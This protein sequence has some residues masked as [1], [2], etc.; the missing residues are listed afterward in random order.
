LTART[1]YAMSKQAVEVGWPCEGLHL[2]KAGQDVAERLSS[3]AV[4]SLLV[5]QEGAAHA[6]M[7]AA[8]EALESFARADYLLGRSDGDGKPTWLAFYDGRELDAFKASG[9]MRLGRYEDA[10]E[11]Y[12]VAVECDEA[13]SRNRASRTT[14]LARSQLAQAD[15]GD[16]AR[17]AEAALV[18][19]EDGVA[20]TRVIDRLKTLHEQF[21][22]YRSIP[23]VSSFRDH[24][25][26]LMGGGRVDGRDLV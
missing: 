1:Y 8:T 11:L 4:L 19:V 15:V 10:E 13:Y 25:Q 22:D 5:A 17:T 18:A 12:R 14:N 23:A 7:G 3:P 20:S 24:Y 26:A 6:R 2:A 21:C 9:L 16:A